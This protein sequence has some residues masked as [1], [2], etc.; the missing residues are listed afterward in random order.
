M[1]AFLIG[2]CLSGLSAQAYVIRDDFTGHTTG[3]ALNGTYTPTGN[4][5]WDAESTFT[6]GNDSTN[7]SYLSVGGPPYGNGYA[8]VGFTSLSG[9]TDIVRVQGDLH[10]SSTDGWLS[11]K[12]GGTTA[13]PVSGNGIS[14]LV[15]PEG[16][17]Q[18]YS[19]AAW[20]ANILPYPT[21]PTGYVYNAGGFNTYAMEYNGATNTLNLWANG[22]QIVTDQ[23]IASPGVIGLA[24][25][26]NNGNAGSVPSFDNFE[27]SVVPEP[28]MLALLAVGGLALGSCRRR[29]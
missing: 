24:G 20:L 21:N 7:G 4:V 11:L 26:Y 1:G 22:T 27:V 23:V 15:R 8:Q 18:L 3:S 12:M 25:L 28:A 14:F 29:N 19:N 13:F 16:L 9:A 17:V 2:L 5:Q 10:P 6:F